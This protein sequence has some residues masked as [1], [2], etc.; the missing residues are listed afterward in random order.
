MEGSKTMTA[1]S[2]WTVGITGHRPAKVG[3]YA[4]DNPMIIRIKELM[5]HELVRLRANTPNGASI[6]GLSGMA[7]GIDQLFSE[8]CNDLHIRWIAYVPCVGQES[9]WPLP[10]QARYRNLL[11]TARDTVWT[12]GKRGFTPECMHR[13]NRVLVDDSTILLAVWDG[14]AGGTAHAVGYAGSKQKH[15]RVLDP[16]DLD[17]GW[18]PLHPAGAPV[19]TLDH[20]QGNNPGDHP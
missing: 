11:H 12:S 14:S 17:S 1:E 18:W 15:T 5:N 20:E 4:L 13:R 2:I 9:R 10:A 6:V 19:A 16:R 3:G 8:V 7:L